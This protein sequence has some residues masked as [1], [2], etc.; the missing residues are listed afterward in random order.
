MRCLSP[1]RLKHDPYLPGIHKTLYYEVPC[2]KCTSC[3]SNKRRDWFFRLLNEVEVSTSA[4]FV[5]L[6]YDDLHLP[7]D[8]LVNKRDCQLFLKRLRKYLEPFKVKL[9][10]FLVSEY[11][12]RFG[13][14][15][16]HVIFFNL[17]DLDDNLR[18][19]LENCWQKGCVDV[20]TALASGLNYVCKYCLSNLDNGDPKSRTFL[21]C[22][23]RPALG[24]SYMTKENHDY[25]L[26][27]GGIARF[28]TYH[29][30]L[31]PRYYLDRMF[32]EHERLKIQAARQ[33]YQ[34]SIKSLKNEAEDMRYIEAGLPA[35]SI[36]SK[37]E[38]DIKIRKKLKNL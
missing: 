10:Y 35:L 30:Q 27:V 7:R 13:R 32:D 9:R 37:I 15:H 24:Y 17:P 2:G 33:K 26:K 31:L 25:L 22:S 28:R 11:G 38:T 5:T 3:L 19:V 6:T 18:T 34:T 14:A 1:V 8:G 20:G 16:Y 4:R 23:R 29:P 36:Q 21:L 12:E